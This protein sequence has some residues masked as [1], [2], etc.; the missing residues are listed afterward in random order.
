SVAYAHGF[1]SSAQSSK[2][3]FL[4]ERLARHGIDVEL[5]T[6]NGEAGPAALTP[7]SALDALQ[8]HWQR[9]GGVPLTLVGS[10]FGGWAA[11]R[12]A[13]L[14]PGRVRR[15]LL[16]NPGFELGRRWECI[17][18]TA[19]LEAWRRDGARTFA[20]PS[21][22]EP[23]QVPWSFVE[24]TRAEAGTPAVST[25][26]VVLHGRRD[27]VVPPSLSEAFVHASPLARLVLLED[28]HA[29]TAPPSLERI[30][31]EALAACGGEGGSP[32][33]GGPPRAWD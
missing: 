14:H 9:A 2:G 16:L 17:V 5:L 24:Q 1:L 19:A 8:A 27:E 23:C 30:A 12:Y 29:L 21:T 3:R 13:E 33:V 20:M 4:R 6:L 32:R 15:L 31:R 11:A 7:Q 22:G 18:G 10:S 25:E 26:A 28:D